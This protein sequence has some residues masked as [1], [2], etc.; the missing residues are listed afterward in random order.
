MRSNSPL[1]K[2]EP[3]AMAYEHSF[4]ALFGTYTSQRSRAWRAWETGPASICCPIVL[5]MARASGAS[6]SVSTV[7]FTT[8]GAAPPA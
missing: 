3:G 8:S 6:V 5:A 4:N 7:A 1:H 2:T